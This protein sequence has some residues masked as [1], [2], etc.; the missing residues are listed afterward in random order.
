MKPLLSLLPALVLGALPLT[1]LGQEPA[2]K[3]APAPAAVVG[4]AAPSLRLN[5]HTGKVAAVGGAAERWTILAF[6]PKAA[7]P[8]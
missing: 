6:Y 4:V 2:P 5:D 8:G 1:W 7:T 3:P